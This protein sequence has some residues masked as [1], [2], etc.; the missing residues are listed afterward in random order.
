MG[1]TIGL[2]EHKHG[3]SL[4]SIATNNLHTLSASTFKDVVLETLPLVGIE[5]LV[6]EIVPTTT[7]VLSI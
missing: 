2:I 7:S 3:L 4:P 1:A 6:K 5:R